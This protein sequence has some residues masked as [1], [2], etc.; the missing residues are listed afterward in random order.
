[1][2]HLKRTGREKQLGNREKKLL[3]VLLNHGGKARFKDF[4]DVLESGEMS[5][6][7]IDKRL[8]SLIEIGILEKRRERV[9]GRMT[10]VY[11]FKSKEAEDLFGKMDRDLYE[12]AKGLMAATQEPGLSVTDRGKRLI[13]GVDT[14]LRYQRALTLMAIKLA[15]SAPSEKTAAHRFRVLMDR[16]TTY[17]A[18]NAMWLC[19]LN[20]DIAADVLEAM[21]PKG[22]G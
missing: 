6:R 16:F 19:W 20:K 9:E 21:L 4:T 14:L 8:K 2:D 7:T 18:G 15:V 13:D 1:M 22:E 17:A 10:W 3:E 11:V 5:R 12:E